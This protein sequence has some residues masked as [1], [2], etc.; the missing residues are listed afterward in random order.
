MAD[1]NLSHFGVGYTPKDSMISLMDAPLL[2]TWRGIAL[3]C[4]LE[5]KIKFQMKCQFQDRRKDTPNTL[6]VMVKQ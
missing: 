5:K 2:R 1:P 4:A 6:P 3:R